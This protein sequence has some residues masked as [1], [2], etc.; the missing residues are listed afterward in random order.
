MQIEFTIIVDCAPDIP[1]HVQEW[2]RQNLAQHVRQEFGDGYQPTFVS[3]AWPG[4]PVPKGA[5]IATI[6]DVTR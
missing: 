5:A 1:A 4:R 6:V 2:M 3:P